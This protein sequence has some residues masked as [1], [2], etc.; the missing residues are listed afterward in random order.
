MIPFFW[1][2]GWNSIQSVNKYQD[3]VGHSLRD[4]DPGVRLLEPQGTKATYF[5]GIPEQFVPR[6]GHLMAVHLHHIYGSEEL[7]AW[8]PP[9]ATRIPQPY[10]LLNPVD[11]EERNLKADDTFHFDIE[12]QAYAMPVKISSDMPQ[13]VAG[14]PYGLAGLPYVELPSWCTLKTNNMSWKKEVY[15]P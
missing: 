11:A 13:G 8:S 10:V 9:V 1:S 12:D 4:G 7:S 15:T 14:L 6:K 2:P 3:E 5:I